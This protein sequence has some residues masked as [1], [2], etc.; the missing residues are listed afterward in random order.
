VFKAFPWNKYKYRRGADPRGEKK[1][2]TYKL[3]LHVGQIVAVK[4]I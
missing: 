4:F 1:G 3:Q 2:D